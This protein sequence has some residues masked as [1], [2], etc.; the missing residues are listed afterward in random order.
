MENICQSEDLCVHA[1]QEASLIKNVIN[2][3]NKSRMMGGALIFTQTN[4]LGNLELKK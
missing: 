3:S 4:L 2:A 1:E